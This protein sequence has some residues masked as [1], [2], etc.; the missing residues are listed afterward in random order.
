MGSREILNAVAHGT[1][2]HLERMKMGPGK[3]F[4]AEAAESAEEDRINFV[5]SAYSVLSA[6]NNPL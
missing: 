5:F 4:N 3:F 2:P 6:F 1:W